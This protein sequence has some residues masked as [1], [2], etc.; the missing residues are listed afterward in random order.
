MPAIPGAPIT[1]ASNPTPIV[2]QHA[3]LDIPQPRHVHSVSSPCSCANAGTLSDQLPIFAHTPQLQSAAAVPPRAARHSRSSNVGSTH[4]YSPTPPCRRRTAPAIGVHRPLRGLLG[5]FHI[6]I[7]VCACGW[8]CN[9][10]NIPKASNMKRI[11]YEN[12]YSTQKYEKHARTR[13][14]LDTDHVRSILIRL[15]NPSEGA[16]PQKCLRTH[17][18]RG[19][20]TKWGRSHSRWACACCRG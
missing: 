1:R 16:S 14:T 5:I 3:T 12:T 11:E 6:P 17:I 9:I 4:A 19:A 13:H 10:I 18:P 8:G 2:R 7:C 20:C 15:R